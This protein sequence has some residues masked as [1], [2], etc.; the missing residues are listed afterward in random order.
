M[1]S[2]C[3]RSLDLPVAQALRHERSTGRT[4]RYA[5][6]LSCCASNRRRCHP[7]RLSRMNALPPNCRPPACFALHAPFGRGGSFSHHSP[8]CRAAR[9]A[10]GSST[11]AQALRDDRTTRPHNTGCRLIVVL[12]SLRLSAPGYTFSC[13]G[14]N[15]RL[16]SVPP[17]P[18]PCRASTR[19]LFAVPHRAVCLQ[20]AVRFYNAPSDLFGTLG[21]LEYMSFAKRMKASTA[22][23]C[24]MSRFQARTEPC[25]SSGSSGIAVTPS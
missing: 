3:V 21:I 7:R 13:S 24:G 10:A 2:G 9:P 17:P 6:R 23:G 11:C 8:D 19:R 4:T 12:S 22:R 1:Q 14:P 25:V 18:P 15:P 5:S 20:A 16:A